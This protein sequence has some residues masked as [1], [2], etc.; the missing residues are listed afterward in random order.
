MKKLIIILSIIFAASFSLQAQKREARSTAAKDYKKSEKVDKKSNSSTKST[1]TTRANIKSQKA[2]RSKSGKSKAVRVS[3]G[4][5]SRMN[6]SA[7]RNRK[8]TSRSVVPLNGR[9]G[10]TKSTRRITDNSRQR[11]AVRID[12]PIRNSRR[13]I[14]NVRIPR[15]NNI[16]IRHGYVNRTALSFGYLMHN[17]ITFPMRVRYP[18]YYDYNLVLMHSYRINHEY[19]W[20]IYRSENGDNTAS[21]EGKVM[22]VKYN[23]RS[24]QY[25]IHFG[26]RAPYQSATIIIP[27]HLTQYI[28][29]RAIKKLKRD[30]VSVY[31]VFT[32]YGNVPTIRINSLDEFYVDEISLRDFLYYQ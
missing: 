20:A 23:R 19:P 25:E 14:S 30:Y 26:R 28:N 17:V 12:K 3:T 16:R 4:K 13:A 2:S 29:Y 7:S 32:N 1:R 10:N 24:K 11:K 27:Q 31:G 21:I 22:D 6:S 5:N 9:N 8:T 15:I 18:F